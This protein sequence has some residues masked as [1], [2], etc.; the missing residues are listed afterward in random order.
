MLGIS[1]NYETVRDRYQRYNNLYNK[2]ARFET[3]K[4]TDEDDE[5]TDE[6][7]PEGEHEDED[8]LRR[9]ESKME[10]HEVLDVSEWEIYLKNIEPD[11]ST[12]TLKAAINKTPPISSKQALWLEQVT[13]SKLFMERVLLK[14]VEMMDSG[15]LS[16]EDLAYFIE[17]AAETWLKLAE[18]V[19]SGT[20]PFSYMETIVTMEPDTMAL[21]TY[22]LSGVKPLGSIQAVYRNFRNL[23]N[24]RHLIVPFVTA[25]RLFDIRDQ[26]TI[27]K[28]YQFV[29]SKLV[30]NWNGI[31][32]E[33]VAR[34]G[35][36]HT[37]DKELAIDSE[38]PET[39]VPIQ[40][41]ASL[42]TDGGASPLIEWLRTKTE[43]DFEA[44]GKILHGTLFEA[45]GNAIKYVVLLFT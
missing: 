12:L 22:H 29:T 9:S 32:M 8:D 21:S 14:Q 20:V 24:V 40:F 5:E 35:V 7:G 4:A 30:S 33:E 6:D 11:A 43:Q 36:I 44:M 39:L 28:L 15:N 13:K 3:T 10:V 34:M 42:V 38:R 37:I 18:S 2:L 31:T 45:Y 19:N 25:L 41:I 1:R 17:D 23:L 26:S 16:G 27:D